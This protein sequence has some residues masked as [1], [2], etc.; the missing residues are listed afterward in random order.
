MPTRTIDT[1]TNPTIIKLSA[2]YVGDAYQLIIITAGFEVE[3]IRFEE[4][5]NHYGMADLSTVATCNVSR[6]SLTI[7]LPQR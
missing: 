7:G 2:L 4:I 6:S 5:I 3:G 1:Q